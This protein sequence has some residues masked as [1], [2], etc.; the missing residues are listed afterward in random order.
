ME[1]D[2]P[3]HAWAAQ[4]QAALQQ[5]AQAEASKKVEV[6]AKAKEHLEKVN[7]VPWQTPSS[8]LQIL[9]HPVCTAKQGL[10]VFQCSMRHTWAGADLQLISRGSLAARTM[11]SCVAVAVWGT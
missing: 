3:R 11:A 8:P 9:V 2:D 10:L 4:N 1:A 7:K 6:L 5:R